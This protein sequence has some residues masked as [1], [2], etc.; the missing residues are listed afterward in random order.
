M[1]K[2]HFTFDFFAERPAFSAVKPDCHFFGE[3]ELEWKWIRMWRSDREAPRAE[4]RLEI[5]HP[6]PVLYPSFPG[7]SYTERLK[8][9]DHTSRKVSQPSHGGQAIDY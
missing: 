3:G 8:L 1:T 5:K 9:S 7:P 6:S 2:S 4:R